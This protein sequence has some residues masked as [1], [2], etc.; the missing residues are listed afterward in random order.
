MDDVNDEFMP[1]S[2]TGMSL[3]SRKDDISLSQDSSTSRL[4]RS[5]IKSR[6]SSGYGS[7][8]ARV[9][10]SCARRTVDVHHQSSAD[11]VQFCPVCQA[12]FDLIKVHPHVHT[13]QCNVKFDELEGKYIYFALTQIFFM[14]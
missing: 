9:V 12:P 8:R 5:Y 10:N 13:H 1:L 3:T 7:K 6:K 4:S 11:K 14:L 2:I